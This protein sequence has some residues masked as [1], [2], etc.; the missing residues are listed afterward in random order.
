MRTMR[1]RVADSVLENWRCWWPEQVDEAVADV[2]RRLEQSVR[3]WGLTDLAALPGGEL[4]LVAGAMRGDSE[5]VLK[6]NPAVGAS[7][8][9]V[10]DE[11]AALTRWKPTGA[12]PPVV[13]IRDGGLTILMARVRPGSTLDALG[14]DPQR[15]VTV[16]G[17]LAG[18]LH[19]GGEGPEAFRHL[20]DSEL[21]D[22]W[23]RALKG[24]READEL[25][26]LLVP[27]AADTLL[28]LDLHSKNV[29]RS[30][31][32]WVAIDPKP[33]LGD[34]HADVLGVLSGA[35]ARSVPTDAGRAR[36]QLRRLVSAYAAAASLDYDRTAA[37]A[38]LR[39]LA[40]GLGVRHERP[41]WA[42]ELIRIAA[43]LQS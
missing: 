18:A 43:A 22:H 26:G 19:R 16:L 30:H 5:V 21:A 13:G 25:E 31:D 15:M 3:A 20:S 8:A 34:P 10:A 9:E 23:R 38:R 29:L 37:W 12:V 41:A 4:A 42:S 6:L 2:H 14:D 27:G 7:G 11:S 33:H 28:H 40:T 17:K 39:A 32:R 36:E 35:P 1:V 24:T